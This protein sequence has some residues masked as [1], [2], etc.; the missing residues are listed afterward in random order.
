MKSN[1]IL[2]I[3]IFSGNRNSVTYNN[4][5][6]RV[7]VFVTTLGSKC[8]M[9]IRLKHTFIFIK[10]MYKMT[11]MF[12]SLCWQRS[13]I[14]LSLLIRIHCWFDF[15]SKKIYLKRNNL[16]GFFIGAIQLLQPCEG[17]FCPR[18]FSNLFL[19]RF[20]F[21]MKNHHLLVGNSKFLTTTRK[22]DSH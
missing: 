8:Q 12:S 5:V 16:S 11:I 3:I 17:L 19:Q 14:V 13:T 7:R 1:Q 15:F 18:T 6:F 4:S 2:N 10:L 20:L 21:N 22:A 9:K